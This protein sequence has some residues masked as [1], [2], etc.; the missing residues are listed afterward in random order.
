MEI[1]VPGDMILDKPIHMEN[2][3]IEENKTYAAVL[4][5][6]DKERKC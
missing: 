4:G 5:I 3:F 2:T 6:F 1:V